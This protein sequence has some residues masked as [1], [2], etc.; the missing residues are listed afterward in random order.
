M[1]HLLVFRRLSLDNRKTEFISFFLH[2][3]QSTS[4]SNPCP[5]ILGQK[6]RAARRNRK[7]NRRLEQERH[8]E[9]R[10][11][12][13]NKESGD[14]D[15]YGPYQP[16]YEKGHHKKK[17]KKQNRRE[18]RQK[19]KDNKKKKGK[20]KTTKKPAQVQTTEETRSPDFEGVV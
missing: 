7:Q 16:Q 6:I 13:R 5:T 11:L 4:L 19:R 8:R 18:K 14:Y 1:V 17:S 15:E 3:I 9:W 2:E 10:K 20:G 12:H